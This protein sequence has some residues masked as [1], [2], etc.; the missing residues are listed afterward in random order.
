MLPFSFHNTIPLLPKQAPNTGDL[1][2][3]ILSILSSPFSLLLNS[4]GLFISFL[5]YINSILIVFS[6]SSLF[7][8]V[9]LQTEHIL[10]TTDSSLSR[11]ALPVPNMHSSPNNIQQLIIDQVHFV[12]SHFV[13]SHSYYSFCLKVPLPVH[14]FK[15]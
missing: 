9:H 8:C 4:F 12:F 5:D 7:P 11:L 6:F 13:H 15:S 1:V 3:L 14:S 2:S 10:P